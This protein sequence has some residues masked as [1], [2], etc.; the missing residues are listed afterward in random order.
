MENFIEQIVGWG[1]DLIIYHSIISFI[2]FIVL[3]ATVDFIFKYNRNDP[4]NM[5]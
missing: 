5:D 4:R 3:I 1:I 2:I